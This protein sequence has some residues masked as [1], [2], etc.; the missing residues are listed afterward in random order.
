MWNTMFHLCFLIAQTKK[1]REASNSTYMHHLTRWSIPQAVTSGSSH[2]QFN[3]LLHTHTG[4][5]NKLPTCQSS[6]RL[7]LGLR[8]RLSSLLGPCCTCTTRCLH[9]HTHTHV[10]VIH[11]SQ[12]SK[13][14]F[15]FSCSPHNVLHSLS[16]ST[17]CIIDVGVVISD[18]PQ[19]WVC[20]FN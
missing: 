20:P 15:S 14:L 6:S 17:P 4:G 19:K 9:T 16:N 8:L 13:K 7:M 3:N 11:T 1:G 12:D 2:S 10:H 18:N 5:G